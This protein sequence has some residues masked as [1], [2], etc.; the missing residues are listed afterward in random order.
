MFAC[1]SSEG[2]SVFSNNDA[3]LRSDISVYTAVQIVYS[4]ITAAANPSPGD[5]VVTVRVTGTSAADTNKPSGSSHAG[6]AKAVG[7]SI[8]VVAICGIITL[9]AWWAYRRRRNARENQDDTS[10]QSGAGPH[11]D[12]DIHELDNTSRYE[13]PDNT[14]VQNPH[15]PC[16]SE[17]D[18]APQPTE[19]AS[20]EISMVSMTDT[21][22][23]AP[24]S[25]LDSSITPPP[26]GLRS[27]VSPLEPPAVEAEDF[28]AG[29]YGPG[30]FLNPEYALRDGLWHDADRRQVL[31]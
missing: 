19:L 16:R 25:P 18:A 9:V 28:P 13:A 8:G 6:T 21:A 26:S 27:P 1:N 5:E 4:T 17:L 29:R 22:S 31:A 23:S 2:Y 20:K 12:A 14:E 15:S 24:I 3:T 11:K 7:I 10:Q 30:G